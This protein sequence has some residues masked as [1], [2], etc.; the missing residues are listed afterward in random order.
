M[1][2]IKAQL[3]TKTHRAPGSP[4]SAKPSAAAVPSG[5]GV[6]VGCGAHQESLHL[7]AM[8]LDIRAVTKNEVPEVWATVKKNNSNIIIT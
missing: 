5:E 7:W 8:W 3:H 2:S 4:N 1:Y 6:S